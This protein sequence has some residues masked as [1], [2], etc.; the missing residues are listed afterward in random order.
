MARAA[1][2]GRSRMV[3]RLKIAL[4]LMAL[5]LLSALFLW[6]RARGPVS[7]LRYST[8]DLARLGQGMAVE[9]PS[10]TGRTEQGEP[11]VVRAAVARPDAPDP[12]EVALE[13]VEASLE[14]RDGAQ[15]TLSAAQGRIGVHEQTLALEGGVVLRSS[16]GYEV[17]A[18]SLSADLR[19]RSVSAPGPVRAVGPAG[20]IE[21]GAFRAARVE[22]P[23]PGAAVPEG[24]A[25]GDYFWFE[26]RVR[27]TY[28]PAAAREGRARRD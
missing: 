26:K 28:D 23:R 3:R 12:A 15:V 7:G 27:V 1:Y 22:A 8:A 21:A 25:P 20:A 18:P 6:P 14:R 16:D 10:F 5:A 9:S 13:R 24:L 19:G 11:F 17:T 4:P 2:A